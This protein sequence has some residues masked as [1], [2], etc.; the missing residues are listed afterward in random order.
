V[1]FDND[2]DESFSYL[3]PAEH[4]VGQSCS[5]PVLREEQSRPSVR[6]KL[7]A[8]P[9]DPCMR[10]YSPSRRTHETPS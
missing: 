1:Y 6:A 2:A 4:C 5:G 7:F 8:N 3:K 10:L 9:T